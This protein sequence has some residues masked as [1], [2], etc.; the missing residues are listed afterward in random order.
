MCVCVCVCV[1]V[2][3]LSVHECVG[4]SVY[5]ICTVCGVLC[6]ST[7]VGRVCAVLEPVTLYFHMSD[8]RPSMSLKLNRTLICP[9]NIVEVILLVFMAPF[10]A[11]DF[12]SFPKRIANETTLLS[13][14]AHH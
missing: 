9:Y 1:C 14:I 13:T 2:C 5:V 10:K 6:G 4:R 11:L 8:T 12:I 7:C 3:A